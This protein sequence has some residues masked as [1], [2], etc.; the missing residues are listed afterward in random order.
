MKNKKDL[1]SGKAL[2][3]IGPISAKDIVSNDMTE[4]YHDI[5]KIIP[6]E[7]KM[8]NFMEDVFS[9]N[10]LVAD[11]NFGFASSK[12]LP[13]LA[14][15]KSGV[16]AIVAKSFFAGFYKNAF[17]IG[18]L[19]LIANTDYIDE[20]D[21]LKID[22]KLSFIQNR[23]KQLGIKIKPLRKYFYNLYLN[24]GLLNT[25]FLEEEKL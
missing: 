17:S 19:C 25:L 15:Q 16:I 11:E 21:D 14:L 18:L 2:R 7:K 13:A 23:T 10:I 8:P 4:S 22:L 24:G 9:R 1:L 6:F 5:S 20:N 12:E 3:V